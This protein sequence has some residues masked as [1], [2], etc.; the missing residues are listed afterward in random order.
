MITF[1]LT[2]ENKPQVE[3]WNKKAS[4]FFSTQ[5]DSTIRQ[6]ELYLNSLESDETPTG[7]GFSTDA[8]NNVFA[9]I[10]ARGSGK[11]SC[12]LS[13]ANMLLDE[14]NRGNNLDKFPKVKSARFETIGMIDPTYIEAERNVVS[15]F[16]G[17]LYHTFCEKERNIKKETLDQKLRVELLR[18][19]NQAQVDV[20][21]LQKDKKALAEED[22]LE[23]LVNYAA[24]SNLK[25]DIHELV[26]KYLEYFKM[27][28]NGYLLLLIDDIDLNSR[29][30]GKMADYIQRYFINEHMVVFMSL[31]MDQL[32]NIKRMEYMQEYERLMKDGI[33]KQSEIDDM[34]ERY[35]T[36]LIPHSQRVFMPTSDTYLKERLTV[37]YNED[38]N[39]KEIEYYSIEQAIP[40]LIYKKTR[41]LFYNSASHSSYIVPRNLRELRQLL[42]LLWQMQPYRRNDDIA[43]ISSEQLQGKLAIQQNNEKI[44][45]WNKAQFRQYFFENWVLSNLTVPQ[46]E[47]I[48]E[49]K[50]IEDNSELNQRVL[51]VLYSM[52]QTELNIPK[53]Y[54][55][56]NPYLSEIS[57]IFNRNNVAY[58]ISLGD[59]VAIL[60]IINRS[61]RD[62]PTR[63]FLFAIKTIYS[64]RLYEAYDELT[65]CF[66]K[67][68]ADMA[69]KQEDEDLRFVKV[70]E[71]LNELNAYEKLLGGYAF[72][73]ELS[74]LL[75]LYQRQESILYR[76]IERRILVKE[77]SNLLAEPNWSEENTE[78][79]AKLNLI[80]VVI[81]CLSANL[82]ELDQ[83]PS[84]IQFERNKD[85]RM[86]PN[87]A[88]VEKLR[89]ERIL[90]DVG[91]LFFNL[92]RI[93][94]QYG[95]IDGGEELL[96]RICSEAVPYSLYSK[97]REA[98][99]DTYGYLTT[100][101]VLPE[102][103]AWL[104]YCSIRNMEVLFD[105]LMCS[106]LENIDL[107]DDRIALRDLFKKMAGYAIKTYDLKPSKDTFESIGFSFL[108]EIANALD[109]GCIAET[110]KFI[111]KLSNEKTNAVGGSESTNAMG[112]TDT[113]GVQS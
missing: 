74:R 75:P 59:V 5:Y 55:K 6:I 2:S 98:A 109:K 13:V 9:F 34:V 68:Q 87:V 28:D 96:Q 53:D 112:A 76:N 63:K 108:I 97:F 16:L 66:Y 17:K 79:V 110:Y 64:I 19:F 83:I 103:H 11:S 7:L 42:S 62:E 70:G 31:K 22:E 86:E 84:S 54:D 36:K 49:I 100:N 50:A 21:E 71:E 44:N 94:K 24:A 37:V 61:H 43:K 10:G 65:S 101:Q 102:S 4:S 80:E 93:D 77:I 105:F 88:F 33:L 78:F 15:I 27:Q 82:P 26:E 20:T 58:R 35:L 89:S 23:Q 29:E 69:K 56:N 85:Y 113:T 95:R 41:Y 91:S 51:R 39:R 47:I 38:G 107:S 92:Q 90:F 46:R 18:S 12:M 45:E 1:D 14:K 106:K 57:A 111:L 81:M 30:A 32:E 52:F 99:D 72:N 40:Q 25:N 8:T 60:D 48:D 67:S 73:S 104:S 3:G